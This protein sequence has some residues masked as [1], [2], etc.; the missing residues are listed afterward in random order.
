MV[1]QKKTL[2]TKCFIQDCPFNGNTTLELTNHLMAVHPTIY[3][4]MLKQRIARSLESITKYM[5]LKF[6]VIDRKEGEKK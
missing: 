5:Q 2:R 3:D 4:L 1:K 6:F